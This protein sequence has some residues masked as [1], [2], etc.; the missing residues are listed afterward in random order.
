MKTEF[1]NDR[2]AAG[3]I[4]LVFVFLLSA[5]LFSIIG[6]GVDR[7]T[8]MAS[9]TL[10]ESASQLRYDVMNVQLILF[11]IEPLILLLGAGINYWINQTRQFGGI[12][13]LGGMLTSAAEMILSTFI[14]MILCF[15]GGGALDTVVG[16]METWNFIPLE[17]TYTI[18]QYLAPTF[19]GFMT[20]LIVATIALFVAKC[21][22]IVDYAS[23][24]NYMG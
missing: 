3:I 24:P 23:T 4:T 11:R 6:Y 1:N 7:L 22:Q 20:L 21:F 8:I 18:I 12:T 16:I 10:L 13:D 19:Y 15:T 17:D 5:I 14:L 9:K 2:A